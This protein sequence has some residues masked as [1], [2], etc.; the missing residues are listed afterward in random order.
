MLHGF[1]WAFEHLIPNCW[2]YVGGLGSVASLED[3]T[4]VG[5]R[6]L[7][8][9]LHSTILNSDSLCGELLVPLGRNLIMGRTGR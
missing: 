2:H 8:P 6:L 9:C 3:V 5:F 1:P 4:G 7:P